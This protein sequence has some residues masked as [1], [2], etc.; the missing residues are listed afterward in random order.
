MVKHQSIF[1]HDKNTRAEF[2]SGISYQGILEGGNT[3]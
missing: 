3:V 2:D 1:Y